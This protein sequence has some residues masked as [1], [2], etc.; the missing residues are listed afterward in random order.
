[1]KAIIG[2]VMTL[3]ATVVQAQDPNNVP[4]LIPNS[5]WKITQV[6][7]P[8][9]TPVGYILH[10]YTIGTEAVNINHFNKS[11]AG[12]RLVCSVVGRTETGP[13]VAIYWD[14]PAPADAVLEPIWTIDGKVIPTAQWAHQSTLLYKPAIIS[15]ELIA[16]MKTGHKA[17][18]AWTDSANVKHN[19]LFNL[20]GFATKLDDFNT[21]C[22][23]SI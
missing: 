17:A 3:V 19:A 12:L 21:D 15:T 16:A 18:I 20:T 1:M 4:T 5:E 7:T 23:S 13:I 11:V 8:D 9:D 10:T 2:L 6:T 22:G 14:H